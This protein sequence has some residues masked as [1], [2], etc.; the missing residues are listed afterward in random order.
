VAHAILLILTILSFGTAGFAYFAAVR[1]TADPAAHRR[2][3]TWGAMARLDA[4]DASLPHADALGIGPRALVLS[5]LP[6]RGLVRR[7]MDIRI[8]DRVAADLTWRYTCQSLVGLRPLP[9]ALL[10]D[11]LAAELER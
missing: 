2:I 5:G 4:R 9:R 10:F 6:E 7:A 3:L 8:C 11:A 1:R